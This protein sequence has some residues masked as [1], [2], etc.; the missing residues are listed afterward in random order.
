MQLSRPG[1]GCE[2]VGIHV[3]ELP[4]VEVTR[5]EL[6]PKL[7]GRRIAEV[8]TTRKS[9]FFI[10]PP[11]RLRRELLGRTPTQLTRFGKYLLLELD[12]GARLLLHL[13][14][15]GQL[16]FSGDPSVRLLQAL[17]GVTLAPERQET[18]FTPDAHTH[19]VL[20]FA[21]AGQSLYF[22]DVRKFGKVELL[23]PQQ[24]SPRLD[25]LGID[26]LLAKGSDL[27]AASRGRSVATKTLLL[28]Q[29]VLAGVGNIYADE[30]LFIA[31]VSPVRRANRLKPEACDA[32]VAATQRVMLRSIETG[33]S[34]ISDYVRPDGERG[35]YQDER[36][37]YSRT[38]QA[39]VRCGSVI[40]RRVLGQRSTHYCPKCQAR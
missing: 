13:G 12:D 20:S 1:F 38:G 7:L 5:R 22:R 3:P 6:L 27:Y 14:M 16:F 2:S 33:G 32:I 4:E 11:A 31:G 26:A 17:R 21:D 9:Y 36:Q 28:D 39:C 25:K 34:S 23:A 24:S 15:T 30:A 35:S 19:L 10:T 40:K 37:V 8:S 29:S 18:G